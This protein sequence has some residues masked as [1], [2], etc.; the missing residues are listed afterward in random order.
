VGDVEASVP[1]DDGLDQRLDVGGARDVA[2]DVVGRAAL[3][4]DQRH[5]LLAASGVDVGDCDVR[6]G[7]SEADRR[8]AADPR[9]GAGDEPDAACVAHR[10][11]GPSVAVTRPDRSVGA[12]MAPIL[13]DNSL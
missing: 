12:I 10:A 4:G 9:G 11:S 8:G 7:T 13:S 2:G 3:G 5:R 6:A 1:G